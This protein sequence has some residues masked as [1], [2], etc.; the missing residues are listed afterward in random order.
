MRKLIQATATVSLLGLSAAAAATPL[1]V[2]PTSSATDLIDEILGAGITVTA[3]SENYI[4]V[5]NQSGVFSGGIAAGLGF[6]SGIILTTG[7]AL[8]PTSTNSADNSST[9]TNSGSNAELEAI[10]GLAT[11]DQAVL[12][13]DFETTGGDVFFDF[14]FASEE[15]NE[16]IN[17]GVNDVFALLVDGTNIA[18]APNGDFVSIDTV[19]CGNPFSSADNN[20]ASFNNNDLNDGGPFF[21]LAYDGF[22]DAFTAS[23]LGLSA[24]THSMTFAI[25]DGGDSVWDSAVFIAANSFT[26]TVP[27]GTVPEPGILFL[28]G[29]GLLGLAGLRRRVV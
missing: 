1:V 15:Y 23:A 26:D 6:D 4:G 11:N 8:L 9:T 3:G 27:D 7:S 16:F 21:D 24:G 2:T 22:T 14:I 29:S 18:L 12:S 20:C 25:A 19:N 28:L 5:S 13:F 10:G 17:A